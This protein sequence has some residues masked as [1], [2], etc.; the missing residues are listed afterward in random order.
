MKDS[1]KPLKYVANDWFYMKPECD[2][3][4]HSDCYDNKSA[5][6]KLRKTTN[7]LGTNVTQYSD[8]KMLYNRELLFTVNMLFGLAMLCYY[9]YINQSV[10]TNSTIAINS[11]GK[12]IMDMNAA[13]A[14]M[15]PTSAPIAPPK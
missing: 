15:I 3:T 8:T 1:N 12:S 4:E 7:D 10:I 9:I 13:S 2:T 5:V 14:S 6:Q 11:V